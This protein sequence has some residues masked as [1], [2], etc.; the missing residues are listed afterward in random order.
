[1]T[2]VRKTIFVKTVI[3]DSRKFKVSFDVDGIPLNIKERKVYAPGRPW[4]SVYD[5]TIWHH[6]VTPGGPQATPR[7]VLDIAAK[8]WPTKADLV[9]SS[10]VK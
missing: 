7:Q 10:Q 1:M 9:A 4:E 3:I 2:A 6:S 5:D 8:L